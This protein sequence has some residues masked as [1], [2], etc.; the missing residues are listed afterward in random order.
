MSENEI[1]KCP[2]QIMEQNLLPVFKEAVLL[3]KKVSGNPNYFKDDY[4]ASRRLYAMALVSLAIRSANKDNDSEEQKKKNVENIDILGEGYFYK[5]NGSLGRKENIFKRPEIE[6]FKKE[7]YK[8]NA[9][10]FD[11]TRIA[12]CLGAVELDM[13]IGIWNEN[14]PIV[15]VDGKVLDRERASKSS[16]FK[17][18][19]DDI[20]NDL[21]IN[22]MNEMSAENKWDKKEWNANYPVIYS[23]CKGNMEA[24]IAECC[25][26]KPNM[27][28]YDLSR[29]R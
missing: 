15:S 20:K 18:A 21:F 19:V 5:A 8:L 14:E 26:A 24:K 11:D 9:R 17:Y 23:E 6:E 10:Y 16:I 13:A 27:F 28:M 29:K 25:S 7:M 22:R 2:F 1:Y 12:E 3:T 4:K